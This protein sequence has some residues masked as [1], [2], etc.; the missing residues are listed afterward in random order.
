VTNYRAGNFTNPNGT[1]QAAAF[2]RAVFTDSLMI[3]GGSVSGLL[4]INVFDNG[5]FTRSDFGEAAPGAGLVVT[6]GNQQVLNRNLPAAA[7]VVQTSPF[8]FTFGIPFN[9]M[10]DL[11]LARPI[12]Q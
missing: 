4:N 8:L 12:R 7:F 3:M 5:V 1:S 10:G 11:V 6:I 9:I 2:A